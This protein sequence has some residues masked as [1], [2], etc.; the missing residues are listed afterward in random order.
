MAPENP[1]ALC[2]GSL[3][4]LPSFLGLPPVGR[5]GRAGRALRLW[6]HLSSWS[7]A[8]TFNFPSFASLWAPARFP[9]LLPSPRP[10]C[11]YQRPPAALA[12]PAG[13]GHL[14]P[15]RL[16]PLT[17]LPCAGSLL[18][19]GGAVEI[20]AP[21][22]CP[23]LCLRSQETAQHLEEADSG[24]PRCRERFQPAALLSPVTPACPVCTSHPNKPRWG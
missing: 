5:R 20:P 19:L 17:P 23:G 11:S 13:L 8:R 2:H 12:L 4:S 16:R 6:C 14:D 9:R 15:S 10:G 18:P 3:G 22:S 24:L 7:F 1:S 21:S